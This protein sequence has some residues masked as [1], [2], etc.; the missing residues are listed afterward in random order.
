MPKLHVEATVASPLDPDGQ[1]HAVATQV[2]A[3]G[4]T[5]TQVTLDASG[6][7]A[8]HRAKV[9]ADSEQFDGAVELAGGM[10]KKGGWSGELADLELKAADIA[11]L[12]LRAPSR[13]ASVAERTS[14]ETLRNA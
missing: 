2:T 9:T 6:N 1:V 8:K 11:N 5:F 7:Q 14:S 12:K 3:G 13:V 4:Q 10:T